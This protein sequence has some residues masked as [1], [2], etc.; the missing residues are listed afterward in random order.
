MKPYWVSDCG[1]YVIYCGDCLAILPGLAGVDGVITDPPYSSGGMV[2]GDRMQPAN[3]KYSGWGGGGIPVSPKSEH[4]FTGDS[5]DQRSFAYWCCLWIGACQSVSSVGA[6]ILMF[7]DW[8]QLPSATD[9]MQGGGWIWRGIVVWD[10]GIA[11]PMKGRFRNHAEYLIWGS[12]GPIDADANPVYLDG[13]YHV[14]PPPPDDRQHLTEKP[15]GIIEAVLPVVVPFGV[16]LDPFMGSGTTG[17]ACVKTGRR[18]VG[19]EMDKH[20]CDVA[21][22]RI[23]DAIDETALFNDVDPQL[24]QG[25]L[26]EC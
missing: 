24:K 11:R 25:Q 7:T 3:Q 1:R 6:Q 26:V 4:T 15:I 10:K 9:A 18:F 19:I 13:V 21:A 5:R 22:E 8:R 23:Q 17:V 16:V 12:N 14:P 20:Y 2:R